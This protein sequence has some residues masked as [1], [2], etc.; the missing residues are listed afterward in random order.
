M[1]WQPSPETTI[2]QALPKITTSQRC[3]ASQEPQNRSDIQ[4]GVTLGWVGDG[5]VGAVVVGARVEVVDVVGAG[6]LVVDGS[7]G[8]S[9]HHSVPEKMG[10]LP[11][12]QFSV[13]FM[14]LNLSSGTSHQSAKL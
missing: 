7:T 9:T 12:G 14:S 1:S 6:A 3:C 2:Y 11:V 13:G 4:S 5:P 8:I 10:V